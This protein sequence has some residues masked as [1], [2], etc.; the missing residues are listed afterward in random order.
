MSDTYSQCPKCNYRP[1]IPL[2]INEPCPVFGI[3]AFK[4]GQSPQASILSNNDGVT[5]EREAGGGCIASLFL[6]LEKIDASTIMGVASH[7]FCSSAGASIWLATTVAMA[8]YLALLYTVFCS[9]SMK[10]G[11]YLPSRS[12]NS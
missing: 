10:V 6:P 8:K 3:Y 5:F 1:P 7:C 12:A 4:W 2:S 11:M 9:P